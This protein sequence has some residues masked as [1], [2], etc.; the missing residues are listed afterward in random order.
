MQCSRLENAQRP[1]PNN[2]CRGMI[3]IHESRPLGLC[4]APALCFLDVA[5][6]AGSYGVY[7]YYVYD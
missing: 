7:L 6:E 3:T 2:L 1:S 4:V 5:Y